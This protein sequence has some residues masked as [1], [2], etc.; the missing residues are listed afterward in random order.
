MMIIA[1]F[2]SDM[3]VHYFDLLCVLLCSPTEVMT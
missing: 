1:F 3:V 2:L